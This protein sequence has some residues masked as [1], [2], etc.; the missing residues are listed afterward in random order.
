[1]ATME[2]LVT[3]LTGVLDRLGKMARAADAD[4]EVTRETPQVPSE[5]RWLLEDRNGWRGG[6]YINSDYVCLGPP[7]AEH[8]FGQ[9]PRA[10]LARVE[11]EQAIVVEHELVDG[12]DSD[13]DS[14]GGEVMLCG[15][16][17]PEAY[18]QPGPCRTLRLLAYGHRYDAPGYDPAWAPEGVRTE[19]TT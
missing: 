4:I 11:V 18:G 6:D 8:V 2:D 19:T 15:R 7:L 16:C 3:W 9:D 1:M 17:W 10:V 5:R 14:E 13:D 12:W